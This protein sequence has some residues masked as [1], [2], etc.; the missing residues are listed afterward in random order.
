MD[1]H[2]RSMA[3]AVSWR[4]LGSLDT[5]LL[6]WLFSGSVKIAAFVGSTEAITKIF[7]YWGHERLWHRIPWGRRR[8]LTSSP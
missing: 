3:K 4:I 5:M 1:S 7:L 8:P 2:L 6:T